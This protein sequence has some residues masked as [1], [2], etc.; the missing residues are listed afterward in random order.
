GPR[1]ATI[2]SGFPGDGPDRGHWLRSGLHLTREYPGEMVSR[3]AWHGDGHGDHGFRRWRVHRQQSERLHDGTSAHS[4]CDDRDDFRRRVL[5]RDV[6]RLTN[7]APASE[8][9]ETRGLGAT[10]NDG[11]DD[12]EPQR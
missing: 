5:R 9:L 3:S 11:S 2:D 8:G 7:F 4:N 12:C 6:D 10:D 1:V